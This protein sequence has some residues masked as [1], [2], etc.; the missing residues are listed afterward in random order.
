MTK[1]KQRK[2]D[3]ENE[4]QNV[5][6]SSEDKIS[7]LETQQSS[8]VS[9]SMCSKNISEKCSDENYVHL[10]KKNKNGLDKPIVKLKEM[11]IKNVKIDEASI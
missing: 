2:K 8:D 6:V 3:C 9:K 10:T 5:Y 11:V 1:I 7:D 4:K